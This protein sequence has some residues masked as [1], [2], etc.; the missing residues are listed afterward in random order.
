MPGLPVT[1]MRSGGHVFAQQVVAR[2]RRRREV[3][4]GDDARDASV[5][6]LGKRLPAIAGA[7]AGLD[8]ARRA[9]AHRTPPSAAAATVVVSPWTS[10]QSGRSSCRIGSRR[11]STAAATWVGVW[12]SCMTSRS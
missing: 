8:V 7:Q 11:A 5:D 12:L 2:A 6:L 4:V 9:R 1:R 10:T 3:A